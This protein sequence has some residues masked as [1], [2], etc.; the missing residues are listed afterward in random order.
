M[1]VPQGRLKPLGQRHPDFGAYPWSTSFLLLFCC[2]D[3]KTSIWMS[4]YNELALRILDYTFFKCFF[5]FKKRSIILKIQN[6]WKHFSFYLS[7]NK[8]SKLKSWSESNLHIFYEAFFL[9]A[10]NIKPINIYSYLFLLHDFILFIKLISRPVDI[11]YLYF[12]F[13]YT[14]DMPFFDEFVARFFSGLIIDLH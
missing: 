9:L 6:S 1:N 7:L 3:E 12:L 8:Q 4:F 14:F 10:P 2:I 5:T 11:K 13:T